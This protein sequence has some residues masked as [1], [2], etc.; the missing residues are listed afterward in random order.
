MK[1]FTKLL[2][3]STLLA[4]SGFAHANLIT[5][6][7]DYG[8]KQT[9]TT[10][11]SVQFLH[12]FTDEDYETGFD[13]IVS[14]TLVLSLQDKA[15]GGDAGGPETYTLTFN[16][17]GSTLLS[18]ANLPNGKTTLPAVQ[19]DG[20]SLALLSATGQLWFTLAAQS[21]DFEFF[22]S[23]LTAKYQEGVAPVDVPE[24]FSV[25]LVGIGL[26]AIGAARRRQA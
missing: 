7:D 19:I 15:K 3:A 24:P 8:T 20:A 6:T 26:A 22:S 2:A 11:N 1:H 25:A 13:S 17:D 10:A 23:T 18:G 21:G 4:L 14:A 5:M 12:D 9:V 16:H